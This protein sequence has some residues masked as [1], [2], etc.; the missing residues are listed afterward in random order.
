VNWNPFRARW[1]RGLLRIAAVLLALPD[2]EHYGYPLSLRAQVSSGVLYL[3]LAQMCRDGWLT[4]GWQPVV[5]GQRYR[6]RWYRLTELG[7][8][9]LTQL[10]TEAGEP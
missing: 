5:E 7:R 4:D 2:D 6:R 8:R 9:E 1:E 10:L 3:V